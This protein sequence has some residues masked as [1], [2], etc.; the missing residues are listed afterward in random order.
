MVDNHM[1]KDAKAPSKSSGP[2][3]CRVASKVKWSKNRSQATMT[4]AGYDTFELLHF[5]ICGPMEKTHLVA[6]STVL[7]I[8]DEASGC[9]KVFCSAC[10]V[11]ERRLHQDVHHEGAEAVRQRRLSL[12]GTTELVSLRPTRSRTSTK[13]KASSSKTTVPYATTRRNGTAER[14]PDYRHDRPQHAASRQAGQVFLG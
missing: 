2:S 1:I 3:L 5:D 13:T 6:A 10:Q 4:S 7:L 8:V 9:M 12:C 11:G 14:A